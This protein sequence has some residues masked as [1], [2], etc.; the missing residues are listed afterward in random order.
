MKIFEVEIKETLRRTL[1]LKAET[2]YKAIEQAKRLYGSE[3]IVFD[4]SD[5]AGT[6]FSIVREEE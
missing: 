4:S 1:F 6:D 3:K 5:F 2:E